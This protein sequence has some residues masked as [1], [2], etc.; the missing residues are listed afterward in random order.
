MSKAEKWAPHVSDGLNALEKAISKAEHHKWS[1]VVAEAW[2]DD[3]FKE[4]L[5]QDPPS[6]RKEFGIEVPAG[7]EIRVVENTDKVRYITL[8]PKPVADATEL[9]EGELGATAAAFTSSTTF[10]PTA[11]V[12]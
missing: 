11:D 8:P 1:Q 6:A 7:V 10:L 3:K 12:G 9:Y 4:R 5:M 2:S